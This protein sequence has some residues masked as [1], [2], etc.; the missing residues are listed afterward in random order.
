MKLL[1]FPEE[2]SKEKKYSFFENLSKLGRMICRKVENLDLI[3]YLKG[4]I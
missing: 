1:K 3:S 2:I 4:A